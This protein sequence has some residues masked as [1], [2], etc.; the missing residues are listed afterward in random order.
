MPTE[1]HVYQCTGPERHRFCLTEKQEIHDRCG[2]C[3][4][5]HGFTFA[6]TTSPAEG[7]EYNHARY[8]ACLMEF[9]KERVS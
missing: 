6:G 1:I 2:R 7:E 8:R 5:E 4:S 3:F 9:E